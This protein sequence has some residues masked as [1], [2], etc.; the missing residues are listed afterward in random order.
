MRAARTEIR[1]P[2]R[3]KLARP[4]G[5]VF[6]E[7]HS[8]SDLFR[9]SACRRAAR[10]APSRSCRGPVRP[11]AGNSGAPSASDFPE[12][13]GTR[14]HPIQRVAQ[15]QF[16]EAALFLDH[17]DGFQALREFASE[18]AVERERHSELRHAN[19]ELVQFAFADAQIAQSLHQVVIRFARAGDPEPR[20]CQRR[21]S[22]SAI[23]P[24]KLDGGL[25][26]PRIHF[27]FER[28]RDRRHQP[29]RLHSSDNPPATGSRAGPDP[30][31]PFRRRRRYR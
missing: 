17:Q 1:R 2:R 7:M 21:A 14:R 8:R 3:R 24:R 28:Q 25:Q 6:D 18:L 5:H 29:R 10:P 15:M 30:P 20:P 27:M 4:R 11:H 9:R 16:Q 13:D 23:Q 31:S 12:H 26:S 19:A 22:D